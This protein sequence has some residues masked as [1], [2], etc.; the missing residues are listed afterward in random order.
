[1]S[2]QRI[3]NTDQLDLW[4]HQGI[5]LKNRI[6]YLDDDISTESVSG[7]IKAISILNDLGSDPITLTIN[8]AGGDETAGFALYDIIRGS[9]APVFTHGLGQVGSMALIVFM[10]G[11]VRTCSERCVFMNHAGSED[12]SGK[13]YEI[14]TEFRMFKQRES[15]CNQILAERSI[16]DVDYWKR[17][18][19]YKEVYYTRTEALEVGIITE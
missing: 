9:A 13:P 4:F 19:V 10:A 8:S 16:K 2:K 18:S 15:W 3:V 6:I 12:L 1:M 7:V 5:D 11:D 17:S 14:E